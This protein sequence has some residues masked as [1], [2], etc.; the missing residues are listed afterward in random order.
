MSVFDENLLKN[1]GFFKENTIP[2]RADIRY[3]RNE[4]ELENKSSS[5]WYSLKGYWKFRWFKGV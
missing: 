3:Y 2:A 1:P 4:D 5:F